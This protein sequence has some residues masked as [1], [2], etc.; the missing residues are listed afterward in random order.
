VA[1]ALQR[2]FARL[3]AGDL[4]ACFSSSVI[5]GMLSAIGVLLAVL[6]GVGTSSRACW[7]ACRSWR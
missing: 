4:D 6:W 1:G 2:V 3:R 7:V 5:E